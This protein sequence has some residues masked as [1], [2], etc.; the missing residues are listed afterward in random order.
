MYDK[1]W[2]SGAGD[3]VG[4]NLSSECVS[5]QYPN[6]GSGCATCLN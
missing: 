4:G 3:P 6:S 1:T 2:G 5:N